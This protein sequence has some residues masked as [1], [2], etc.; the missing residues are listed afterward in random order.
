MSAT[1]N[2][3]KVYVMLMDQRANAEEIAAYLFNVAVNDMGLSAYEMLAESSVC[4][5]AALV[6]LRPEFEIH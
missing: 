3:G 4:A 5:A 1:V 2:I 6:R